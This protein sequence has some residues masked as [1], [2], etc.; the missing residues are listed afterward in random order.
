MHTF[1][2][3]ICL[4]ISLGLFSGCGLDLFSDEHRE[5]FRSYSTPLNVDPQKIQANRD[6]SR[7][8]VN[9]ALPSLEE[10][11]EYKASSFF[12]GQCGT[13]PYE[14]SLKKEKEK[15]NISLD[16]FLLNGDNNDSNFLNNIHILQNCMP[17][18]DS[19]WDRYGIKMNIDF[20]NGETGAVT[21]ANIVTLY[22]KVDRSDSRNYYM[23]GDDNLCAT[24][25]HEVG[26]LM[27]LADEYA[28][29]GT[30][31]TEQ[32]EANDENPWSFMKSTVGIDFTDFLP[33]H[34]LQILSQAVPMNAYMAFPK[35]MVGKKAVSFKNANEDISCTVK[36]P[37]REK[38]ATKKSIPLKEYGNYSV[39]IAALPNTLIYA[40]PVTGGNMHISKQPTFE[41]LGAELR[42]SSSKI[43]SWG[44]LASAVGNEIKLDF[45]PFSAETM[46]K[47]APLIVTRQQ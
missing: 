44:D 14:Y 7:A 11:K 13:L 2:Q 9:Q 46:R 36:P 33:R 35:S 40:T 21:G 43:A 24:F 15:L 25:I 38:V 10:G 3:A 18:M 47:Y 31:R 20:Y 8:L 16:L 39:D 4:C 12:K 23:Q 37:V 19:V 41:L 32:F 27:G 28:E 30:C 17:Q 34:I 1:Y 26:H 22:S 29:S 6:E 5:N 45:I 42:C